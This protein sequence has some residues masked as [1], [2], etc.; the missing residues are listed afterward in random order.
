MA[1]LSQTIVKK[2]VYLEQPGVYWALD[3]YHALI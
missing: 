2:N 1:I 3:N